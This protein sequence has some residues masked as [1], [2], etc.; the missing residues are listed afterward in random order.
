MEHGFDPRAELKLFALF[1]EALGRVG[2]GFENVT[3]VGQPYQPNRM[4]QVSFVAD[5]KSHPAR[6]GDPTM[7]FRKTFC[8]ELISKCARQGNF[9]R[10]IIVDVTDF[11]AAS[12]KVAPYESVR[13]HI[14]P[15]P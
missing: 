1:L 6:F 13:M 12:T 14:D 11:L 3:Q 4:L 8:Q 9:N 5:Q 15:R 10:T 7:L 2:H